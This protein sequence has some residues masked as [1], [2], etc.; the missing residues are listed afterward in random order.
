MRK[1]LI[2]L[3]AV[4]AM[5]GCDNKKSAEELFKE[6]SSGVVVVLNEYYY[7]LKLPNGNSLYFT[8]LDEEGDITGLTA[9]VNE[10]K[11]NRSMLTGTAF[12]VD[13]KGT[14]MTNRHVAAPAIDAVTARRSMINIMKAMKLYFAEAMSTLSDQFDV[15]ESQKSSC[16]YVDFYGYMHV[17]QER[18][19]EINSQQ[20]E[21]RRQYNLL[22]QSSDEIDSNIDPEGIKIQAV[23]ELGIAY[24]DT[25]VT[26]DKDFID[27]NPCVV[28]RTSDKEDV[29][30]ALIQLKNKKTPEGAHIFKL[31]GEGGNGN[32]LDGLLGGNGADE[33]LKIDQ[34]LYM[35][36][37]NAGLVLANTSRE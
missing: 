15:L 22:S 29:D 3:L 24:N 26:T 19:A 23:C 7:E 37:Y 11:A 2:L 13:D 8:G 34:Q 35:I 30:L 21:L 10:A 32:F 6:T 33:P 17:D 25:Y 14:L 27:K 12:F 28:T 9:D 1:I 4:I 31:R 20:T 36:G 18:L 16:S 5:T